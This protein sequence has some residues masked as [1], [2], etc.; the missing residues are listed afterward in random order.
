[1]RWEN[2]ARGTVTV[3][4]L[5]VLSACGGGKPPTQTECPAG[6][7]GVY[8]DCRAVVPAVAITASAEGT[9]LV[10][11][12]AD[13]QYFYALEA[14]VRITETAGG[15]ADWNY[16]R[17]GIFLNGAEIERYEIGAD[18]IRAAGYSRIAARSNEL[19]H[20][21]YRQNVEDFDRIDITLGFSDLKDGHPFEV[22]VPFLFDNVGI[23]PDPIFA[24]ERGTVRGESR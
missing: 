22:A 3:A 11:P 20:I 2:L 1:M 6:Q 7:T 21:V 16:A 4:T 9:L 23:N 19:Y 17:V 8:P 5:A 14:P 10:H 24:P 13:P 18:D 12:S 15:T